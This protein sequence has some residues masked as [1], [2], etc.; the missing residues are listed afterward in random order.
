MIGS[1]IVLIVTIGKS[2]FGFLGAG[3]AVFVMVGITIVASTS[4]AIEYI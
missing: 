3:I 4:K 2:I 1:T